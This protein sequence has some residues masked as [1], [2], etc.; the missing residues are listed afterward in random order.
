MFNVALKVPLTFFL[1]G[2]LLQRYYTSGTRIE[3][4][5]KS[6]DCAPLASRISS[7]EQT[8]NSLP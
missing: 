5:H 6:L 8:D 2:R 1:V 4:L 3:V 7:F